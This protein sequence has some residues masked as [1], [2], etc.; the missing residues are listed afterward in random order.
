MDSATWLPGEVRDRLKANE[1]NRIN[2]EGVFSL[3]CQEHRTQIQN[4]KEA[5]SKLR[6]IVRE[7]WVR[8]KVRKMRKGLSQ[9]TK[10]NRM[11]MKRRIGEKKANRK[12]VDF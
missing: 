12:R 2:N 10:E 11:E 6:E 8:P 3:T 4:R 1:A 5:L 7:S 9:K